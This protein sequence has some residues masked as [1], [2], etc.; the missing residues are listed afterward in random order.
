MIDMTF[1]KNIELN[2]INILQNQFQLQYT[3]VHEESH[4]IN[5]LGFDSLDRIELILAI[6]KHFNIVIYDE[7]VNKLQTVSDVVEYLQTVFCIS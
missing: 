2:I 6:E 3:P 1:L 5:D 4:F 7:R